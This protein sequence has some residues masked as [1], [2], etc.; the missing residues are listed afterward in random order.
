MDV[1]EKL[2]A[3]KASFRNNLEP[4]LQSLLESSV[5]LVEGAAFVDIQKPLEEIYGESHKLAGSAKPYGFHEISDLSN[6]LQNIVLDLISVGDPLTKNQVTQITKLINDL[7]SE[8]LKSDP[9]NK[10]IP[11]WKALSSNIY[12]DEPETETQNV[13]LVDDDEDFSNQL[14]AQLEGVGF[15]VVVLSDVAGLKDAIVKHNAAAVIMD[16]VFPENSNLGIETI[17][18]LKESGDI[19]CPVVFLSFRDDIEARLSAVRAGADGYFKKPFD[20]GEFITFFERMTHRVEEEAFRVI[21]IDDDDFLAQFYSVVLQQ[22]GIEIL[23]VN[24]PME[25]VASIN[26]FKPDILLLDIHMP[27]CSGFELA[28]VIRQDSNYV[29]IPI[30]FLTESKIQDAH[31]LSMDVGGDEFLTKDIS[32]EHLSRTVLARARRIR[33]QSD[34]AKRLAEKK[35]QYD[36]LLDSARDGFITTDEKLRIIAWSKGAE[37]MLGYTE[38]EVYGRHISLLY[39]EEEQKAFN[40]ALSDDGHHSVY[41][42]AD[43]NFETNRIHKNGHSIPVDISITL[44][45]TDGANYYTGIYRD[46]SA[47]IKLEEELKHQKFAL[48]EHAIVSITD[49]DGN[50]TYANDKFCDLSGY[51]HEDLIGQNHRIV[52]SFEHSKDFFDDLWKTISS[53]NVWDGTIKNMTKQGEPYWVKATIVPF[54]DEKGV[55][56]QYIAIRTDVTER[57]KSEQSLNEALELNKI[58]VSTSPIGSTIFDSKGNCI[59]AN[60]AVAEII[61]TTRE[62][63]LKINYHDL[64]QWEESGL[65]DYALKAL[66]TNS[67]QHVDIT[68][69]TTFGKPVS[70]EIYIVPFKVGSETRLYFS[71][72]DISIRKQAEEVLA[73]DRAYLEKRVKERTQE[74]QLAMDEVVRANQIKSEFM[75]NMSHELRTPLNAIIGFSDMISHQYLGPIENEQY[76]DYAK[77]ITASSQRLMIMIDGILTIDQVARATSDIKKTKVNIGAVFVEGLMTLKSEAEKHGVTVTSSLPEDTPEFFVDED[78]ITKIIYNLLSNAIKFS[79]EGGDVKLA[80]EHDDDYHIIHVIDHGAGIEKDKISKIADPFSRHVQDPHKAYDGL[81]LGLAITK[82]LVEQHGGKLLIDSEL[83]RGTTVTAI[84]PAK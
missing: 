13:I 71:A 25:A 18:E 15:N 36:A 65:S 31:L 74:L 40:K 23:V 34:M 60:D 41:P 3:L 57:V 53:G 66:S 11:D 35:A 2:E 67:L 32:P 78:A 45:N 82:S 80:V 4:R 49:V 1:F 68:W 62:E 55:P 6:K 47:R 14:H 48:D 27:K 17:N 50:I 42:Y 54:L 52:S 22:V 33:D 51:S 30:I 39:P 59:D 76:V 21:I 38:Q 84:F 10:N 69:K 43:T 16:V 58:M 12:K 75:A 46:I 19:D 70:L 20:V 56:F 79:K 81:G 77:D 64:E 44:W 28:K 83:G 9:N 8:R 37:N 24:D 5:Q 29:T 72:N 73:Q 61:G 7:E 26:V 63:F